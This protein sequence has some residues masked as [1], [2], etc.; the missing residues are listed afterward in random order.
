MKSTKEVRFDIYCKQCKSKDK[1]ENEDPC[2]DCLENGFN[3]D[4]HKPINFEQAD[5]SKKLTQKIHRL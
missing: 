5:E 4:S 3:Y 2:W 1:R